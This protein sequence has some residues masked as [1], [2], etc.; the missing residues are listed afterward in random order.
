MGNVRVTLHDRFLLSECISYCLK[1]IHPQKSVKGKLPAVNV[2]SKIFSCGS[3]DD[4]WNGFNANSVIQ[5]G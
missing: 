5:V 4:D 2:V 3:V 1:K